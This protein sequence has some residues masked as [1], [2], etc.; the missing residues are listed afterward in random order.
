MLEVNVSCLISDVDASDLSASVAE[1]GV[2]A[3]KETLAKHA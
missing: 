3:G 2:N 1:R